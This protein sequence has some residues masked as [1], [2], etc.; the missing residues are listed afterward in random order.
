MAKQKK[1]TA[2]QKKFYEEY[3][4][5]FNRA[6]AAVRAHYSKK[7]ADVQ[8]HLLLKNP[9]GQAYLAELIKKQEQRSEKNADDVIK[10]L[11]KIGFADIK[12]YMTWDDGGVT[13]ED[14]ENVD[15]TILQEISVTETRKQTFTRLKLSDR[16]KALELLGK[17]FGLFADEIKIPEGIEIIHR[18]ADE[19]KG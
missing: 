14:S 5:D 9:K 15:G 2:K 10:Q 19:K 4:V 13:L 7:G 17:H 12:N 6:K 11:S 16:I 1:L 3:V 8:A 18:W